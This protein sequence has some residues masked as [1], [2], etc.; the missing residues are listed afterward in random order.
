MSTP[1]TATIITTSA[2]ST[3]KQKLKKYVLTGSVCV[4]KT[5]LIESLA[6]L[7][8]ATFPEFSRAIINE[9]LKKENGILPWNNPAVFQE[10]Y[11]KKQVEEENAIEKYLEQT[12]VLH[13]DHI[14]MDRCIMDAIAFSQFPQVPIPKEVDE[15]I[16]KLRASDQDYDLIFL[17]EPLEQYE[18]DPGR[19]LKHQESLIIQGLIEKSYKEYGYSLIPVPFMSPEE[20]VSFILQKIQEL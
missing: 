11:A 19:V 10:M 13:K 18:N 16:Q 14:F 3:Q 5:T 7:G 2:H 6:K 9:E 15:H 12:H 4:G 1:T 20:R 8:H 17:L